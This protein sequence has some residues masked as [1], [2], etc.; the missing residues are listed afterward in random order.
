[1]TKIQQIQK[2]IGVKPDDVWGPKSEAALRKTI[3]GDEWR[4]AKAS[5]FADPADVVAFK[6]CKATGKTDK[7]CFAV[8]DNGIGQFGANTAQEKTAMCALHA[9]DMKAIWGSVAAA[10]HKLVIVS[11]QKD[12]V[13]CAVEDRMSSRGRI[14]LNPAAAKRLGLKPPFLVDCIWRLV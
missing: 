8:G 2:I 11:T 10:A 13:I 9:D 3:A 4:T 5:S 12:S 7:Q 14:D 1:M 6:K